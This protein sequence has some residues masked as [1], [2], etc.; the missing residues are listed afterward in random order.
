MN[1]KPTTKIEI[2]AF[3]G[4]DNEGNFWVCADCANYDLNNYT[5]TTYVF[6]PNNAIDAAFGTYCG[7]CCA[8]LLD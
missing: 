7:I 2:A 5:P 8:D 4:T 6:D 3:Y 1:N